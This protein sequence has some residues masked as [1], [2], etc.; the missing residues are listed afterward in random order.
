M[1]FVVLFPT[2]SLPAW[3]WL[4]KES[5]GLGNKGAT[6][7]AV[8]FKCFCLNEKGVMQQARIT[9]FF[10]NEKVY[11]SSESALATAAAAATADLVLP[12]IFSLS[13]VLTATS[14]SE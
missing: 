6:P 1:I 2:A 4:A 7:C 10:S 14:T 11:Y 12:T 8:R 13:F 9:P 5:V 3:P